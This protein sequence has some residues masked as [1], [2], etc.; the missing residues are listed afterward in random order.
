MDEIPIRKK[1][2]GIGTFWSTE[3]CLKKVQLFHLKK[4]EI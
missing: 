4:L 2:R 3:N 1:K